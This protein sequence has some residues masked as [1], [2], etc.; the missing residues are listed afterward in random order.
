MQVAGHACAQI[1]ILPDALEPGRLVEVRRADALAHN[2]PVGAAAL[3]VQVLLRH[4]VLQL[5]PHLAHLPHRLDVDEVLVAPRRA[6]AVDGKGKGEGI[7]K[8]HF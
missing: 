8:A 7:S 4:D 2:V 6:V 1:H 5:L 3:H